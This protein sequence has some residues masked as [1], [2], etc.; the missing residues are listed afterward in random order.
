MIKSFALPLFLL[1]TSFSSFAEGP[2]QI[3]DWGAQYVL[4]YKQSCFVNTYLLTC[5]GFFGNSVTS[6]VQTGRMPLAGCYNV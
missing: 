2:C 1:L 6:F 3:G 5:G 4:A